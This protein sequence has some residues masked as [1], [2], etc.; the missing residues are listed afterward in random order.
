MHFKKRDLVSIPNILTYFRFALVPVFVCLYTNASDNI[1]NHVWAIVCV[2]ASAL[3]DIID[4]RIARKT[5]QITDI[6]K[7]L[8][9]IADKAMEFAM[10]F[11]II[12]RYPLVI[13]LIVVFALKELIS[14]C[15]S[16]YLFKHKKTLNGAMWCGKVCTVILYGVILTFLIVPHISKGLE[17]TLIAI[18]VAAMILAF[19]VYMHAYLNM[20]RELKREQAAEKEN[21]EK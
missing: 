3:T 1:A 18:A 20:L 21:T 10:M 9:P 4:G 15:F 17:Y 7:I 12:V 2:A 8:D 13:I 14:L 16:G 6:G 11:C 5:N 19:V